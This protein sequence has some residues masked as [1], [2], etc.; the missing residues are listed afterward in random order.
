MASYQ[1]EQPEGA[2]YAWMIAGGAVIALLVVGVI[3]TRPRPKPQYNPNDLKQ[4]PGAGEWA[5]KENWPTPA[6][7]PSARWRPAPPSPPAMKPANTP[8]A[9]PPAIVRRQSPN[10]CPACDARA[11]FLAQAEGSGMEV[12]VVGANVLEVSPQA[13]P[14]STRQGRPMTVWGNTWINAVLDV[15]INS[16]RPGDV[17]A[18]TS[19]PVRDS[20]TETQVLIPVG[21]TLHGMVRDTAASTVNLN[22]NSV[23][24]VWD[25]LVLPNGADIVLPKLP[26]AD[27]DG[28]PGLSDKVNRHALQIWGPAILTSAITAAAMLSTTSTYGSYQGYS[29]ESEALGQF[30]NSLGQKSLQNLNSMLGSVRPTIEVRKGSVIRILVREP[31]LPFDAPYQG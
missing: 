6:A 24:V 27:V 29:P 3:L 22:N 28:L 19:V 5:H 30:G 23:A 11:R 12:K 20:L 16:D 13:K 15:A 7:T 4:P 10:T 31:G 14:I 21:S 18:H 9:T 8:A 26:S 17:T 2:G 25:S 1:S